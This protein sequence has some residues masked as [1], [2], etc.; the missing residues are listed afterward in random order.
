[1]TRHKKMLIRQ[2][3]HYLIAKQEDAECFNYT[4]YAEHVYDAG[5]APLTKAEFVYWMYDFSRKWASLFATG[6]YWVEKRIVHD[7]MNFPHTIYEWQPEATDDEI[8]GWTIL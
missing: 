7:S 3:R 8:D 2:L 4:N 6:T 1:V 5:L